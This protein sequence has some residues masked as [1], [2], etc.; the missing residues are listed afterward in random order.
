MST[1]FSYDEFITRNIGFVTPEQQAILKKSRV[2]IP[3]VGGMGGIVLST[4]A[5]LGVENF[6]IA[7][8]DTFEVSNLNRQIFSTL[9]QIGKSKVTAAAH[10][11]KEINPNIKIDILGAEWISLLDN[12]LP[13]VDLVVNG[14]DDV[15]ATVTLMRKAKQYG[16]TVIDAFASSLASVYVVQPNDPRPEEFMNFPTRTKKL[17]ELS[18]QDQTDSAFCELV[19]VIAH[20]S[21]LKHVHMKYAAEMV[22]GKR[23]RISM[24]PMVW[25]TGIMMSYEVMKLLLNIDKVASYRGVFCNSWTFKFEKVK[26]RPWNFIKYWIVRAFLKKL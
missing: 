7:D 11:I 20:T 6:I 9:S 8:I 25:L 3:G 16:K 13:N 26:A 1:S 14:C 15:I 22:T 21:T 18:A 2:F 23:K 19:Y 12:L 10:G 17:E 4:L 24:A 5:R